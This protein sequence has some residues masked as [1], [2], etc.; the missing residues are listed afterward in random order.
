MADDVQLTHLEVIQQFSLAVR[1][2]SAPRAQVIAALEADLAYLRGSGRRTVPA[3]PVARTEPAD[4]EDD[5]AEPAEVTAVATRAPA[6]AVKA[7]A[8][9]PVKSPVKAAVPAPVRA[10]KAPAAKARTKAA[11]KAPT[12]AAA[13][14]PAKAS[15]AR[16]A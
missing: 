11:A 14:A 16:K 10:A 12:K 6:R 4:V 9:S 13:K 8:K 7:P 15:R 1:G 5:D 3:P 2:A